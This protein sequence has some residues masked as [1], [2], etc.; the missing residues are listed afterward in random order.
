MLFR[1]AAGSKDTAFLDRQFFDLVGCQ[2]E[3]S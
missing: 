1:D 2:M 3:G